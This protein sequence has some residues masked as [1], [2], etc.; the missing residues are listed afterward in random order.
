MRSFKTRNVGIN[1]YSNGQLSNGT[2]SI[3]Q[4]YSII[5]GSEV[6]SNFLTVAWK[7]AAYKLRN[8]DPLKHE[9]NLNYIQSVSAAPTA[10]NTDP[11]HDAGQLCVVRFTPTHKYTVWGKTGLSGLLLQAAGT[12]E[13]V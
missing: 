10:V 3:T 2:N 5:F 8:V 6:D 9:I 1:E 13:V 7:W 11:L 12:V 4:W